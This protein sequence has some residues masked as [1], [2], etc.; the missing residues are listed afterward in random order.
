[1]SRC[2]VAALARKISGRWPLGTKKEKRDLVA[3]LLER[4]FNTPF[5][6]KETPFLRTE[7]GPLYTKKLCK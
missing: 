7:I 4:F 2:P 6:F 5:F 3:K 1:M